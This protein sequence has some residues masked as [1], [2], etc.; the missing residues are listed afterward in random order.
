MGCGSS[1]PAN[2]KG[3][4]PSIQQQGIESKITIS[5][6]GIT[7]LFDNTSQGKRGLEWVFATKCGSCRHKAEHYFSIVFIHGFNGH[8][9]ETW[10]HKDTSFYWPSELKRHLNNSRAMVFGYN[11]DISRANTMNFIRMSSIAS[12]MNKALVSKRRKPEV[13]WLQGTRD[14]ITNIQTGIKETNCLRVPQSRG[15]CCQIRTYS[16]NLHR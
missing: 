4:K 1:K 16:Q 13:F 15:A 2:A 9:E 8:P 6:M 14:S 3:G 7:E 5:R 12:S 10:T 11:A